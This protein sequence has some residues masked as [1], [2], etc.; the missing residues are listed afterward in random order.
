MRLCIKGRLAKLHLRLDSVPEIGELNRIEEGSCIYDLAIAHLH[1]PGVG[2]PIRL[3]VA[4]RS[5]RIEQRDYCIPIRVQ[6]SHSW[7]QTTGKTC[8]ERIY[9]NV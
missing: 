5:L 7:N 1:V 8:I 3:P 2:V 4:G 9:D 6:P